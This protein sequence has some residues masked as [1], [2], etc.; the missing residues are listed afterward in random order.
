MDKQRLLEL[1]GI[2]IT[3]ASYAGDKDEQRLIAE[4]AKH[5]LTGLGILD[6]GDELFWHHAKDSG[7]EA[8]VHEVHTWNV[9]VD[10]VNRTLGEDIKPL[11]IKKWVQEWNEEH[12]NEQRRGNN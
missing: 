3:E 8:A 6:D 11:P 7:L 5:G 2:P 1:A 12:V 9:V 4:F 10:F